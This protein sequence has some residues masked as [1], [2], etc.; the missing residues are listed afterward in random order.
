MAILTYRFDD[1]SAIG[2]ACHW[3][4]LGS[5]TGGSTRGAACGDLAGGPMLDG[6]TGAPA[7][8]GGNGSVPASGGG[9][10]VFG[11]RWGLLIG[12]GG[13]LRARFSSK[14]GWRPDAWATPDWEVT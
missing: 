7:P 14:A 2:K 3:G 9:G 4:L 8:A 10:Q 5:G 6:G 1:D 13:S 11:D 12:F